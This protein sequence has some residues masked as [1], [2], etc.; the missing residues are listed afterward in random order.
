L[1]E[2]GAPGRSALVLR[3]VTIR[4]RMERDLRSTSQALLDANAKLERL[5]NTD[6]LT[7]IANRRHF[8]ERLSAE[9]ER[10]AR[11]QRPLSLVLLDL[12][13]FKKVNDTHGHAAGDDALRKAAAVLG[14]V[15]RD[16][17][18]AAR[19]GGEELVLLLPETDSGGAHILAERIRGKIAATVHQSPA[20][21]RFSVTA[22]VGVASVGKKTTTP[23]ALLQACDEALYR[24]KEAGRNRVEIDA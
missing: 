17:D 19:L 22:S 14:E 5:A 11:Y 7:G 15:C 13:H 20:G 10:A 2:K 6:S 21:V 9:L 8:L 1:D 24:A 4:D 16:V 12:D 3:D 18:L 23:E